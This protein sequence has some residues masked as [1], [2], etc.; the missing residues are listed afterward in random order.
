M[1]TR[2]T[3]RAALHTTQVRQ[4]SWPS[5][6]RFVHIA[7]TLDSLLLPAGEIQ[8]TS[9]FWQDVLSSKLSSAE[10]P[11]VIYIGS[12]GTC[13]LGLTGALDPIE[14]E[15]GAD[16]SEGYVGG[17]CCGLTRTWLACTHT[18]LAAL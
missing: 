15:A 17:T 10:D 5:A 16:R 13:R 2:A 3:R 6:L 1:F 8:R 18:Q 4:T 9:K 12:A 7:G 14:T 11:S